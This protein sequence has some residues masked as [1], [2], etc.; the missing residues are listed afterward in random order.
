MPLAL[1]RL[2]PA[3]YIWLPLLLAVILAGCQ[4]KTRETNTD[5][6]TD[7]DGTTDGSTTEQ[8]GSGIA[9]GVDVSDAYFPLRIDYSDDGRRLLTGTASRDVFYDIGSIHRIDLTFSQ[10]NWW[11]LLANNYSSE[12]DLAGNMNYDGTALPY[13]V[14]V[15]FRGTTSYSQ[16]NTQKKSFDVDVD[17]ENADQDVNGY[18]NLNLNCAWGD[19]AFMREV[20]Y[21]GV[22][23]YFIPAAAVNYVDLYINGTSWGVYINSQQLNGDFLQEWFLSKKGTR[24]RAESVSTGGGGPG[25]GGGGGFGQGKS[26]LNYLGTSTAG[27][28]PYYTLK[29]TKKSDP[30]TDLVD[31]CT[32]LNKT[33][34]T[35]YAD[36][37]KVMDVD[38]AL[39]FLAC[40]NVFS[41]EDSYIWKGGTDYY[42][43]WESE[44]GRLTPIEYDGNSCLQSGYAAW[45]PFY[46]ANNANYPLL[47]KLLAVPSFRQRYLAHMGTILS[48]RFNPTAMNA[49]IDKHAVLIDSRIQADPKKFMTYAQFLSAVTSLKSIAAARYN[50]LMSNAEVSIQGLKISGTSWSVDGAAWAAPTSSQFVTITTTVSGTAG[51]DKVYLYGATGV[52]GNFSAIR[53]FDDGAHGDGGANDGVFGCVIQAQASGTRVRFYVEANAGNSA[54]T[55]TYDPPGAE[56]D[57][58]TYTVK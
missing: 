8:T 31:T 6:G 28:E 55:K 18:Q 5:T 3:K 1:N 22:N 23:Q 43:Y 57:V 19:S 41:D 11:T 47:S 40:E 17:Y 42:I 38:R 53:M 13:K 36:I 46:N 21:E 54:G 14:G 12:T 2:K 45:S 50:N 33:S 9:T 56:H 16:N 7:I 27:Y 39:W 34:S 49:L 4:L 32:A 37:A 26:G 29:E 20:V 35:S 58:Y 24:W 48:E 44:T 10:S 15:R 30:W 52:V 25:G 51:V